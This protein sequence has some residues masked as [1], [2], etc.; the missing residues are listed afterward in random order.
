LGYLEAKAKQPKATAK[1]QG[2]GK[3][4]SNGKN[5]KAMP[6]QQQCNGKTTPKA[7]AK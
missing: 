1:Q 3:N 6:K 2:N 7:T 4:N 5:S